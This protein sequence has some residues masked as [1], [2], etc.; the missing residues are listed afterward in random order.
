L[1]IIILYQNSSFAGWRSGA[2]LWAGARGHFLPP[3]L[4]HFLGGSVPAWTSLT[5]SRH[6]RPAVDASRAAMFLP[7]SAT[8]DGSNAHLL[9]RL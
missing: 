9:A 4:R 7:N 1:R 5:T 2:P 6:V 8:S 3:R